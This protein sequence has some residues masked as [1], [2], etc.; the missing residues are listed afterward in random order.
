M[1]TPTARKLPSGSWFCRV[2]VGGKDVPITKPTEAEAIAEAVTVKLGLA[3]AAQAAKHEAS[4]ITLEQAIG[5]YISVRQNVLSP[6]TIR[7]Y[8]IVQKYRFQKA[9]N[10]RLSDITDQQWQ[11][12]VNA[13]SRV[14]SA[15][16][17]KNA[18]GLVSSVITET[19]GRKVKVRLPQ[20]VE[21][22]P[23]F[24]GSGSNH[25]FCQGHQGIRN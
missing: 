23:P 2:R 9:S 25:H 3:D 15:K 21:K 6:A 7:G 16:T 19:T 20:S 1:R 22:D 17:V 5:N 8:R 24:F 12:I 10:R 11:Q 4:G 13:E 18:W 14:C